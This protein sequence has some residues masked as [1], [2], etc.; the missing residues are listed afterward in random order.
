MS[1]SPFLERIVLDNQVYFETENEFVI[2]NK[3]PILP[4]H[5]LV[6]PKRPV[7]TIHE[8][9]PNEIKSLF[10]TVSLVSRKLKDYFKAEGVNYAWNEELVAGQTVPHLHIHILPRK[11]N[12]MNPD[13]RN[14]YYRIEKN[15]RTEMNL[16]EIK[17]LQDIYQNLF[18]T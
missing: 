6:I 1:F 5:S 4:G 3:I 11:A 7:L 9:N 13:P 18:V 12:D 17:K 8:L 2:L 16:E 15:E 14:L 10:S